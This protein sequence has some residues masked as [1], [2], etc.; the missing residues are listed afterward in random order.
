MAA[1]VHN[2]LPASL[3][4]LLPH[5]RSPPLLQVTAPFLLPEMVDRLASMLNYFLKYLTGSERRRLAIKDPEKFSFRPRELL[6][7][8]IQVRDKA[9]GAVLKGAKSGYVCASLGCFALSFI[10]CW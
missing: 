10:N 1:G 6:L 9:R 2:G 7:S 5:F 8:I 3:W 4:F